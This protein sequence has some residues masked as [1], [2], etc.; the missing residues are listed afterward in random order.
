MYLSKDIARTRA[1]RETTDAL[2]DA[3]GS[4]THLLLPILRLWR[5]IYS[6]SSS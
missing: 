1:M 2:L 5:I 3:G 4:L 6:Q